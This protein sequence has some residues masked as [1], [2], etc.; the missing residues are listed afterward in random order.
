MSGPRIVLVMITLAL[1]VALMWPVVAAAMA[2]SEQDREEY[3]AKHAVA[4]P[5]ADTV[6]ESTATGDFET[7]LFEVG[8][9]RFV[10]IVERLD[11]EV[12]DKMTPF[13]VSVEEEQGREASRGRTPDLTPEGP[14][15]RERGVS[16][17]QGRY[18]VESPPGS[19]RL[20]VDP[21]PWGKRY[22]VK[23][24]ECGIPSSGEA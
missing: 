6:R 14:L 10:V 7:D 18:V 13:Y 23:I 22:G 16:P 4:C 2:Q 17:K 19:Y 9:S 8:A 15:M 24:E 1:L 12:G 21:S 5:D 20:N 11:L 3:E